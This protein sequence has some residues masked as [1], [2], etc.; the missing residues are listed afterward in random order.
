[1]TDQEPRR[2]TDAERNRTRLLDA[3]AAIFDR[4]GVDAPVRDIAAAAGVGLGTLYR[5]FPSRADLVM[6]VFRHRVDGFADMARTSASGTPLSELTRWIE[7]FV[8]FLISHHGLAAALRADAEQFQTLREYI[9]DRLLPSFA[10]RLSAAIDAGA[11]RPDA[12]AYLTM[13]AIGNLCS[14]SGSD[15][16]Y[17]VHRAVEMFMAG[18]RTDASGR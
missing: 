12:D 7:A 5:H 16:R 1:V 9:L 6:G 15:P 10:A 3:A 17:D 2:R 14:G 11:I 8:E 18:M 4:S 13:Q